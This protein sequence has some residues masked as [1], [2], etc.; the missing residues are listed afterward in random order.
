MR[1][2]VK[3]NS[4]KDIEIGFA[5]RCSKHYD[6]NVSHTPDLF[7]VQCACRNPWLLGVVVMRE[8]EST[9]TALLAL[10][11]RFLYYRITCSMITHASDA[12]YRAPVP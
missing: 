5:D 11:S 2:N 4:R 8:N 7:T 12:F 3:F 6:K 10:L 1:L 9:A